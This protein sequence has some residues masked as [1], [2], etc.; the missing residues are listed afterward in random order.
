MY[1]FLKFWL[2]KNGSPLIFVFLHVFIR[3]VAKVLLTLKH[4]GWYDGQESYETPEDQHALRLQLVA[5]DNKHEAQQFIHCVHDAHSEHL[6]HR[7][8]HLGRQLVT[9]HSDRLHGSTSQCY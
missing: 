4:E 6:I 1:S 8:C 7:V 3:E 9:A 5:K 2:P